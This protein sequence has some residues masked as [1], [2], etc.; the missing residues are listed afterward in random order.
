MCRAIRKHACTCD[1]PGLITHTINKKR[2]PACF[3]P[4][5]SGRKRPFFKHTT[6]EVFLAGPYLT[7]YESRRTPS[8][9]KRQGIC[10]NVEY[11]LIE[12]PLTAKKRASVSTRRHL[13]ITP[14]TCQVEFKGSRGGRFPQPSVLEGVDVF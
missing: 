3:I 7:L 2:T 6:V 8:S 14:R 4:A 1:L 5:C 9:Q 10:E 13:F 11:E 12:E